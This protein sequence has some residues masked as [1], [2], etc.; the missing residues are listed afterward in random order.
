MERLRKMEEGKREHE[1]WRRKDKTKGVQRRNVRGGEQ[2][3]EVKDEGK[4]EYE[5]GMRGKEAR[6]MEDG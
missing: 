2:K 1:G 4:K 6:E 3:E 5:R